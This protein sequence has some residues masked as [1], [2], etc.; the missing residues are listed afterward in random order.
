M[1]KKRPRGVWFS[2]ALVLLLVVTGVA[3]SCVPEETPTPIPTQGVVFELLGYNLP[4]DNDTSW[5]VTLGDVDGDED[6]DIIFANNDQN[7]LYTNMGS[8]ETT[9]LPAVALARSTR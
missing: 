7:R 2:I 8:P 9:P 6:L 5:G 4:A 3:L 1:W